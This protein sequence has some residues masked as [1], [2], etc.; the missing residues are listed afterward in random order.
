MGGFSLGVA[1]EFTC[2][3]LI[4]RGSVSVKLRADSAG[5]TIS[6]SPV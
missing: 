4:V 2:Y 6:F 1:V 5:R 3:C